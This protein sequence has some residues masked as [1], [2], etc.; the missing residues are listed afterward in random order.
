MDTDAWLKGGLSEVLGLLIVQTDLR[1][2]G[3]DRRRLFRCADLAA[4]MLAPVVA[5][6]AGLEDC[7]RELQALIPIAD[8]LTA[9]AAGNLLSTVSLRA[10]ENLAK[11]AEA[12]TRALDEKLQAGLVVSEAALNVSRLAGRQRGIAISGALA[13]LSSVV[14][15]ATVRRINSIAASNAWLLTI[16]LAALLVPEDEL[17]AFM[18]KVAIAQDDAPA[19]A[20]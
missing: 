10:T 8:P 11:W 6:A 1:D 19:D 7:A 12:E 3:R 18:V 14:H 5:K 9:K 15:L 20:E 17:R 16:A 13:I 4:R 2:R